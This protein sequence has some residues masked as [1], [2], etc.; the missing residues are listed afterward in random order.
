MPDCV[1]VCLLACPMFWLNVSSVVKNIVPQS[2]CP[3]NDNPEDG[4]C[5]IL[6]VVAFISSIGLVK[7]T[8]SVIL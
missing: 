8:L 6:K 4:H 1:A 7:L 5:N 2:F 3:L